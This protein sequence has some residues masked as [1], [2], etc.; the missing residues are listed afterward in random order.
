M[1]STKLVYMEDMHTLEG[2]AQVVEVGEQDGRKYVVL[3][4]TILYAQGGGQPADHGLITSTH[5]G[6]AV[7]DVRFKDGLVYHYGNY[8]NGALAAGEGVSIAVDGERRQLHKRLHSGAHVLDMTVAEMGLPWVPG[9]GYHF[10]DGPYVEY[11][12]FLQGVSTDE[13][14]AKLEERCNQIIALNLPTSIRFVSID[15]MTKLCR[16]VPDNLPAGKPAR[17]VL[18]GS[19]GVPCGGTH[20]ARLAEVGRIIIRKI[21]EDKGV[22]K[23]GYTVDI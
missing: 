19:F 14:K 20:V 5:A 18:Y 17:V 15:E 9:K 1:K 8:V 10:P 6:F 23:V 7:T 22:I 12:G 16:F 11:A 21:K 2:S 13:L 3:D 4:Q